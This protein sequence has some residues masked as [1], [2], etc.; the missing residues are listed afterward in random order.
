[1]RSIEELRVW[2][3]GMPP[4]AGKDAALGLIESLAATETA[5]D[6]ARQRAV[7]LARGCRDYNGGYS[8]TEHLEIF[9]HGIDTVVQVLEADRLR[10]SG[11]PDMQLR[12]IEQVGR[13]S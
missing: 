9:H 13:S 11:P 10:G 3:T 6:D 5:R 4:S 2:V 12:V 1:M 8:D 7:V